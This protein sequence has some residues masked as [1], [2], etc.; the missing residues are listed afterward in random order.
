[1]I[2]RFKFIWFL[3][4]LL[5]IMLTACSSQ[6]ESPMESSTGEQTSKEKLSVR[7]GTSS[8]GSP[9]YAL[10]VGMMELINKNTSMTSTVE[11]VGGSDAN[12]FALEAN[13]IE[14]AMLNS[15]SAYNGYYGQPPFQKPVDIQLVAQG[16]ASY[17]QIVVTTKSGIQRVEDL[18]GKKFVAIRPALP[19]IELMANALLEAYKI[20]KDKVTFISTVDTKEVMEALNIGSVDGAIIP[21]GLNSA[22]LTQLFQE[23]KVRFLSIDEEKSDQMLKNLPG[24][25]FKAVI[26]KGTYKGQDQDVNAFAF[27]TYLVAKGDL[28]EQVV[29]DVTKAIMGHQEEFAAIH[30]LAKEWTVENTLQDPKIPFHPGAIRYYKEIGEWNGKMDELQ[31]SLLKQEGK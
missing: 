14:M 1:M 13:K 27:R 25:F 20:P 16:Q 29:Y 10:T 18:A 12:V 21:A 6:T 15:L 26:P 23:G 17:R 22:D 8:S 30:N 24:A 28:P 11:P 4:L 31:A 19:E 5:G 9:F 2:V 7:I 3:I